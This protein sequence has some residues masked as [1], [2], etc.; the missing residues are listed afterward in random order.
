MLEWNS[1]PILAAESAAQSSAGYLSQ[2]NR[3]RPTTIM[4]ESYDTPE[5]SL[6]LN[7]AH[8]SLWTF[9]FAGFVGMDFMSSTGCRVAAQ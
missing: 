4:K 7:A 2:S 3:G 6:L 8:F 9:G 1:C 5:D